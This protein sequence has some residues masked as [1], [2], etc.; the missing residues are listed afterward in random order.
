MSQQLINIGNTA[1]DGT[2]VR[3]RD[4]FGIVN[5]NFTE[6]YTLLTGNI[7]AVN[8]EISG[9]ANLA[10]LVAT[11]SVI[12][13]NATFG[14]INAVSGILSVTG[15]ITGGNLSTA[16]LISATGNITGGNLITAGAL[17]VTGN[18]QSGNVSTTT[19][20]I[21][22]SLHTGVTVS[23]LPTAGV[24]NAGAIQYVTDASAT[25][26]GSVV[27]G[28]GANKVMVWSDGA[29]WKIFAS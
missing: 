2:G 4:A 15:N 23:A 17:S 7:T 8:A 5:T 19:A 28:G 29:D 25:T 9:N 21:T 13:A 6:L 24:A 12:T 10:N 14:N 27:V 22:R 16:G 1:N 18:I 11:N 3:L 26:I 20:A